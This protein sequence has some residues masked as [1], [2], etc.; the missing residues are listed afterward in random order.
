MHESGGCTHF[1]CL[2]AQT[3]DNKQSSFKVFFV[4]W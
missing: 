2:D 1:M 3:L 4:M